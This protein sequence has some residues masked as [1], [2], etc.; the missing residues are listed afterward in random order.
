MAKKAAKKSR[1]RTSKAPVTK[2]LSVSPAEAE[3][4][5]T[6]GDGTYEPPTDFKGNMN[7]GWD[8]TNGCIRPLQNLPPSPPPPE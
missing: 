4:L 7:V 8:S 6:S 2:A 3:A 1:K 5:P